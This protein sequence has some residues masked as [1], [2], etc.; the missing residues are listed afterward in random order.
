QFKWRFS[1]YSA[2]FIAFL[3]LFEFFNAL[4][5]LWFGYDTTMSKAVFFNINFLSSVIGTVIF[6]LVVFLFGAVG[7]SLSTDAFLSDKMPM[8]SAIKEKR[9][10][11]K[12]NPGIFVGYLASFFFLGIVALFYYLG[13][14]YWG[15]WMPMESKYSNMFGTYFPFLNPL[16]VGATAAISEEF[17]FR[18]FA[19]AFIKKYL[20]KDYLA[21][22][23]PALIWAFAHS[24]YAVFPA[25]MRGIELTFVG[26]IMG[27]L[28]LKFGLETVIIAHYSINAVLVSVPLLES[29]NLYYQVSGIAV[30]LLAFVP[31]ILAIILCNVHSKRAASA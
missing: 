15:V 22:I 9:F 18:L 13:T 10:S 23:L 16:T 26:V 27:Y 28:F 31:V 11:F 24:S 3:A 30:I 4:P 7:F 17:T 20:K 19:I 12:N 14:K 21:I 8:I 5:L 29:K 6:G 1:L 25:Y 2:W